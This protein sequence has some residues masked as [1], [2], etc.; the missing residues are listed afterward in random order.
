MKLV[1]F[2][3]KA[4]CGKDTAASHLNLEY[5]FARLA[6]ADPL[7]RAAKEMFGLSFGQTWGDDLKEVVIPRWNMTPRRMFQLLGTEAS[8][9]FFGEDIWIKRLAMSYDVIKD[10]DD[11]IITDCRFD[12]EAEWI[13]AN[14]GIIIEIRRGTT[15]QGEAASHISEAG[16]RLPPDY[17]IDN[18]GTLDDLYTAIDL[19]LAE[20]DGGLGC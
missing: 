9:P 17:V 3:G 2:V 10:T 18:T 19:I 16:L 4:R 5:G 6:F 12:S 11:V 15:L 14:G 20:I 7:K 13:R 8:K 1:A